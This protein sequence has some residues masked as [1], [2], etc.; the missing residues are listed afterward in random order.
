VHI[1]VPDT[2]RVRHEFTVALVDE[3]VASDVMLTVTDRRA[4]QR[5][6]IGPPAPGSAPQALK[7]GVPPR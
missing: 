6:S 3:Q 1:T 4:I 7:V 5:D 2:G